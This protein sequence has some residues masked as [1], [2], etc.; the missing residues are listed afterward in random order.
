MGFK[1]RGNLISANAETSIPGGIELLNRQP[2][3]TILP[4]QQKRPR[5]ARTMSYD[6]LERLLFANF[7][8]DFTVRRG[9]TLS[10]SLRSLLPDQYSFNIRDRTRFP[11]VCTA[12]RN[13]PDGQ[14]GENIASA[15][16]VRGFTVFAQLRVGRRA[17][18][19]YL[20]S[21]NFTRAT[22]RLINTGRI[23]TR[24]RC[25][26]SRSSSISRRVALS[27][28]PSTGFRLRFDSCPMIHRN[29]RLV[30]NPMDACDASR[31]RL[32]HPGG[33]AYSFN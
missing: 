31:A 7:S 29:K 17:S 14:L 16:C 25:G 22:K 27:S 15:D 21:I 8:A 5:R 26:R 10:F 33:R 28:R 4:T 2:A 20:A 23:C 12:L 6:V 1:S 32:R 30:N 18:Q 3:V 11:F 13:E 9:Q 19:I 24:V